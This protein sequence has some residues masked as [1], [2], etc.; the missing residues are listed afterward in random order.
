MS[1]TPKRVAKHP[2]KSVN[3]MPPKPAEPR[4]KKERKPLYV[5]PPPK[6]VKKVLAERKEVKTSTPNLKSGEKTIETP[7]VS[8]IEDATPARQIKSKPQFPTSSFAGGKPLVKTRH[9]TTKLNGTAAPTEISNTEKLQRLRFV[10]RAFDAI[11]I[12][13]AKSEAERDRTRRELEEA[14]E[15]IGESISK[16]CED[17]VVAIFRPI[18]NKEKLLF[19]CNNLDNS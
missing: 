4:P 11:C 5:P 10:T 1:E 19:T 2:L 14:N 16:V 18:L 9:S 12:L 3:V 15:K 13:I 8:K 7:N 17:L 6:E